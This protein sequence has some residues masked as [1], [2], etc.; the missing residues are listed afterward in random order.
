MLIYLDQAM[1]EL[2]AERPLKASR[3]RGRI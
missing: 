3:S 2:H 1:K